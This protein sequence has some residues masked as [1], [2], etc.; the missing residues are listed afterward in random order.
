MARKSSQENQHVSNMIKQGR[1]RRSKRVKV[2][3]SART[4]RSGN[5]KRLK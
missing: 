1:T 5:G 4:S 2:A 3:G